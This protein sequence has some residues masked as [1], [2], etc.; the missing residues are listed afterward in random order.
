MQNNRR[1]IL[2]AMHDLL[3]DADGSVLT[4]DQIVAWH[5]DGIWY[6]YDRSRWQHANSQCDAILM[7]LKSYYGN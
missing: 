4:T 5:V 3:V 1:R 7:S 2:S 6:G